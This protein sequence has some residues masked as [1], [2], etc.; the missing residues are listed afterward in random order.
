MTSPKS[1]GTLRKALEGS[2]S[3]RLRAVLFLLIG[4][5]AA[6]IAALLFSRYIEIR[7]AAA[8]VPT[9]K[10]AVASQDLPEATTLDRKHLTV[11]DWPQSSLPE[12]TFPESEKIIG[13]VVI[14]KIVKGEPLL[15][16]RLAALGAGR[17][18]AAL[19]ERGMRAVAVRVDDVVGVAGFI[20][21]GDSVD[22]IV[23]MKPREESGVL[24]ASKVILQN[25][26]V[27]AVGQEL[28]RKEGSLEKA[29]LT[30]VATLMVDSEQ[31]ER[32][33]LAATKGKI[34]LTLRGGTDTEEVETMGVVPPD[35]IA[36]AAP[37][38]E[39]PASARPRVAKASRA[40]AKPAEG[41]AE[42]KV[43]EIMRGDLFEK[44]DFAKQGG[45]KP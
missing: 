40:K 30:T 24:P 15:E 37:R 14:N 31:S 23:T 39:S 20:H 33:A 11:I 36:T 44:R 43:I 17:G 29:Q 16:G 19:L 4:L 8:R 27:L 41:K 3:S 42:G 2:G 45:G 10:V 5:A 26:R 28:Q 34:L 25:I 35:L 9:V 13:R 1:P 22:V 7:T 38:Q 21:P 18:L 12:G 6:V 32:L